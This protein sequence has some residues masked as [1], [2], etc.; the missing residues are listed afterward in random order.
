MP[1]PAA[2]WWT[3][4][5][6]FGQQLLP[7]VISPVLSSISATSSQ[8][9]T[10]REVPPRGLVVGVQV[11]ALRFFQPLLRHSKSRRELV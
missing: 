9:N 2:Q 11:F 3:A 6:Q 1:V 7:F 5:F 8:A 4:C 10:S